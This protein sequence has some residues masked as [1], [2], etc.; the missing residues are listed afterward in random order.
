MAR[1]TDLEKLLPKALLARDE[2]K[3]PPGCGFGTLEMGLGPGDTPVCGVLR[4]GKRR[5][6]P[7]GGTG[8]VSAR[9]S[10]AHHDTPSAALAPADVEKP[11]FRPGIKPVL[12]RI[13]PT[14]GLV[15]A[16]WP[17]SQ[18]HAGP[19][20]TASIDTPAVVLPAEPTPNAHVQDDPAISAQVA[21]AW[22]AFYDTSPNAALPLFRALT[23][24]APRRADV[25]FGL[26]RCLLALGDTN[27]ARLE[28]EQA[29]ELDLSR[30]AYR[31][32]LGAAWYQ[33]EE[34]ATAIETWKGIESVAGGGATPAM[35]RDMN[36]L[37]GRAYLATGKIDQ[38]DRCFKAAMTRLDAFRAGQLVRPSPELER[39]GRGTLPGAKWEPLPGRLALPRGQR[40]AF[41]SR[42]AIWAIT[43]ET[44]L[45]ERLTSPP[46]GW[47]DSRPAQRPGDGRLAFITTDPKG[48]HWLMLE[49]T[50]AQRSLAL[51]DPVLP[52]QPSWSARGD[53]LAFCKLDGDP[54]RPHVT[55]LDIDS[56]RI[57]VL[58]W[59]GGPS[60]D[61]AFGPG[62]TMAFSAQHDGVPALATYDRA[63]GRGQFIQLFL[64]ARPAGTAG[65]PHDARSFSLTG[66][67]GGPYREAATP[68]RVQEPWDGAPPASGT[69]REFEKQASAGT[70]A[71]AGGTCCIDS[72]A[73]P[74]GPAGQVSSES[75]HFTFQPAMSPTN[76]GTVAFA[77]RQRAQRRVY[78]LDT[79]G[80]V[81]V[82]LSPEA[83]DCFSPAFSPDG[84]ALI[85]VCLDAGIER[86][87]VHRLDGSGPAPLY[88]EAL[89]GTAPDWVAMETTAPVPGATPRSPGDAP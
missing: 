59:P 85:Y 8:N 28:F 21:A 22:R 50:P 49:D 24:T 72:A 82:P 37:M 30:T 69:A 81:A 14:L 6:S 73:A 19:D 33:Q 54:P 76:G 88:R 32:Y 41:A 36:W 83:K 84:T 70:M 87:Y 78:L 7:G 3:Q 71:S 23:G 66:R 58:D 40:I 38:A 29:A 34:F 20:Q 45:R 52:V 5:Q 89:P 27:Q 39:T 42:G 12:W 43:G 68:L 75:P 26:G 48:V 55:F 77:E 10:R 2:T 11:P 31:F 56:G 44:C 79:S 13:L 62:E 65:E 61:P 51:P 1:W 64:A 53:T 16:A 57:Q 15:W 86:P 63:S 80:R 47:H 35:L 74:A 17:P 60:T 18:L 25:H 46:A 4:E 9:V 67:G